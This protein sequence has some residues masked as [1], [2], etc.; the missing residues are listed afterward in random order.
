MGN[1]NIF[2]NQNGVQQNL[3]RCTSQKSFT[4][5]NQSYQ[6]E[7]A[8]LFALGIAGSKYGLAVMALAAVASPPDRS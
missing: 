3:S 6:S 8:L 4:Y 7:Q 5:T 1:S 2:I